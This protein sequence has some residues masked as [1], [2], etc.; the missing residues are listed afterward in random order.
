MGEKCLHN[1]AQVEY[2]LSFSSVNCGSYGNILCKQT[3]HDVIISK[4]TTIYH[5][6]WGSEDD[7]S[8]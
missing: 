7:E 1:V 8:T 4:N 2:S 6:I 3:S 5:F